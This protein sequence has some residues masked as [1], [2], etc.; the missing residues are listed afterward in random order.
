[1]TSAAFDVAIVGGGASGTLLAV[2][3][4]RRA[5]RPG[6]LLLLDRSGDFGLGVAYRT[7]EPLHL[8]N[9]PAAR[10]SA[11]PDEEGHFL[12]WLRVRQPDAGPDA[13]APRSLYGTYLRELA[14]RAE[15]DAAPGVSLETRRAEVQAVRDSGGGLRLVLDQGA[16]VAAGQA[17]LALGNFP[18]PPLPATPEAAPRVWQL[19]WPTE[20]R[21]P[22]P[23]E[24]VLLV[25]A[26][27]TAVDVVLSLIARGHQGS[28][29]LLSRHGLLPH[30]HLP[31]TTPPLELEDL[32]EGRVRP[33]FRA[34]RSAV[35]RCPGD[36]RAA[37]DGLRPHSHRLWRSLGDGERRRFARHVRTLWEIHRHRIAPQVSARMQALLRSGQVQLHAGRLLGLEARGDRVAARFRP[38]GAT[39]EETL[40]ADLVVNCTGPAG[41]AAQPDLLVAALLGGGLARPGPLGLGLATDAEG[42][43]LDAHG[44]ASR[45]L[46]ALGVVRRGEL[47]ESVAVPDIRV[48][49][50]T[51]AG[52]LLAATAL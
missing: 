29:H 23:E 39:G 10:M 37:V 40:Q 15:Q 22:G 16:E 34:V 48:Q 38:R 9:V 24:T 17:V 3:L 46:W 27:L 41:H 4:L 12:D 51:L 33:L 26:S 20:A 11:L 18:P 36:W 19:P 25:G 49:A 31:A 13:Y 5:E 8:L 14:E 50:A 35:S 21:W 32:P 44:R 45:P 47:W 1:V 2:Q 52:R 6:R 7:E 42:R 28:L 43:V 30:P